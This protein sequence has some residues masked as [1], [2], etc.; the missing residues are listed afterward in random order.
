ME[1]CSQFKN[2]TNYL[3]VT[4][5]PL[6]IFISRIYFFSFFYGTLFPV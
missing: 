1:R 2:R 3:E 6:N 4:H 5:V